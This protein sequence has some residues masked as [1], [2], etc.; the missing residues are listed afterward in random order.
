M[1][2]HD[3]RGYLWFLSEPN[4]SEQMIRY[5]GTYYKSFGSAD[6]WGI[7]ENEFREIWAFNKKGLCLFDPLTETFRY[8]QNPL[9]KGTTLGYWVMGKGGKNW[10]A[11]SD[12]SFAKMPIKPFIEFD[13]RTRRVRRITPA[14]LINGFTGKTENEKSFT[15]LPLTSNAAGRVWGDTRSGANH[16]VSYYDTRTNALV[17]YPVSGILASSFNKSEASDQKLDFITDI[18]IDGKYIW[19]SS[20]S[21][22]GLLRLDTQTSQW[23]QYF[24]PETAY[25]QVLRIIPR[26]DQQFWLE[27]DGAPVLFDK[28]TETI[29]TYPHIPDN[30]F[31]PDDN[32][33]IYILGR[34][35]SLWMGMTARNGSANLSVLY[36][37]K[38]VFQI[39]DTLGNVRVLYKKNHKLY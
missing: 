16:T 23:K 19:V 9:V 38:Q 5:D 26:N 6:W 20:G 8:F 28:T 24:I 10:F 18:E 1:A 17:W 25:N 4:T 32:A 3:S 39:S 22:V 11:W 14:R 35:K 12:S 29:Y 36:E 21:H 34:H 37:S 33:Q 13:T 15:F 27:S 30:G 7:K 2:L 31:T